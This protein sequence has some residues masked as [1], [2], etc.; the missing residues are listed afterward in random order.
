MI[1][2]VAGDGVVVVTIFAKDIAEATPG[3]RVGRLQAERLLVAA[4]GFLPA[5]LP[6]GAPQVAQVVVHINLHTKAQSELSRINALN[7]IAEHK[8]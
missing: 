4:L 7:L 6:L 1:Y 3:W 8:D 2:L 5:Q